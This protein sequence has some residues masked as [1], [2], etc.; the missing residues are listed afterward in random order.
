MDVME[1][2]EREWAEEPEDD[3]EII[4]D[5]ELDDKEDDDYVW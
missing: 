2:A 1:Q 3:P 4:D 5:R